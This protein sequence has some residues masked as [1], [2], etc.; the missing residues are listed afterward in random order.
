MSKTFTLSLIL[1][2]AACLLQVFVFS[3]LTLFGVSPD[4]VTVFLAVIAVFTGQR[5]GMT[6]GFAS[7]ILCGLLSGNIGVSLLTRTI[8]GFVAGYCHVPEDS[9]ATMTQKSRMLYLAVVLASFAGNLV[10]NLVKNPLG[11]PLLY[12]IIVSGALVCMM[13]LLVTVTVNRLILRKNL[14]E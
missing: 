1:L 9:H 13:N 14:S 10:F 3:R 8:E 2:V 4:A 5:T 7:G 6:Y 12:R 11:E